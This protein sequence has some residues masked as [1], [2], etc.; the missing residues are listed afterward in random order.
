MVRS[1]ALALH[2]FL[3][4]AVVLQKQISLFPAGAQMWYRFI[5]ATSPTRFA[6]ASTLAVYVFSR[7]SKRVE[8][9]LTVGDKNI[10]CI[11][12]CASVCAASSLLSAQ[13]PHQRAT[14]CVLRIGPQAEGMERDT[15]RRGVQRRHGAR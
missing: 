6:F 13:E 10:T 9:V 1:I 14:H 8:R 11:C 7:K 4:G 15:G 2:R 12:W 3:S 5:S